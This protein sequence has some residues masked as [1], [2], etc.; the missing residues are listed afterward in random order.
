MKNGEGIIAYINKRKIKTTWKNDKMNGVGTIFY[1]SGR[2][3]SV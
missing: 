3:Q 2:V 1:T